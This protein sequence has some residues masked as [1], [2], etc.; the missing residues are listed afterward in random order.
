MV[1][2]E[3]GRKLR[4]QAMMETLKTPSSRQ[5]G[6]PQEILYAP[7]APEVTK[8]RFLRYI[9]EMKWARIII[10]TRDGKIKLR[11]LRDER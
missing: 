8:E 5:F 7:M 9:A 4:W 10:E 6:V 1:S 11:E 3:N 2:Y